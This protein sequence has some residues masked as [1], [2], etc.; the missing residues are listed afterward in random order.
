VENDSGHWG[1]EGSA[2]GLALEVRRGRSA[3]LFL[4]FFILIFI[5]GAMRETSMMKMKMMM[6]RMSFRGQSFSLSRRAR[7]C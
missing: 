2:A 5:A 1:R 7:A 4:F 6:R 3:G